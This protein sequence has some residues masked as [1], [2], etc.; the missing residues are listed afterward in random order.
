MPAPRLAPAHPLDAPGPAAPA[1]VVRAPPFAPLADAP[2][3]GS[4]P[5]RGA[6]P[7]GPAGS[8]PRR[9]EELAPSVAPGPAAASWAAVS[10]ET[11]LRPDTDTGTEPTC[12]GVCR[13][14]VPP[15]TPH[16]AQ[17]RALSARGDPVPGLGLGEEARSGAPD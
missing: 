13:V 1:P 2:L 5:R 9:P 17:R 16:P 3:T 4:A 6:C 11:G 12:A 8:A 7:P 15:L 14:P 10:R